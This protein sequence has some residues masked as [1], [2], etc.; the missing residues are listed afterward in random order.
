MYCEV[1]NM[2]DEP[3]YDFGIRL[4]Q[5]REEHGLSQAALA[6]KLGVSKE[7]IYRYE[8]NVQIPSLERA[9]QLAIVLR[10][11]LDYLTGLE[12][13]Y[14]IQL[15]SMTDEQKNALNE[16]LRVFVKVQNP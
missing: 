9:K 16:F 11:S 8:S 15:P 10:T 2:A 4:R 13:F 3:I 5:L 7:T 1:L 14:T 6:R 12:N